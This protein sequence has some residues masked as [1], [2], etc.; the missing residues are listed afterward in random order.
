MPSNAKVVQTAGLLNL[1]DLSSLTFRGTPRNVGGRG[2]IK[3]LPLLARPC[4]CNGLRADIHLADGLPRPF[5]SE[6]SSQPPT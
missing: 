5:Q 2:E 3:R 1:R 6:K 4:A